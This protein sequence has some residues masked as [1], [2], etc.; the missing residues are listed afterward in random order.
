[1]F[2]R[3]VLTL[4]MLTVFTLGI[5][6]F[7]HGEIYPFAFWGMY[8][9]TVSTMVEFRLIPSDAAREAEENP[10][11][12]ESADV[13]F[14]MPGSVINRSMLQKFGRAVRSGDPEAETYRKSVE[15]A[16]HLEPG[17]YAL[18]QLRYHPIEM[19]QHNQY[20]A[21]LVLESLGRSQADGTAGSP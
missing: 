10:S 13:P 4:L 16:F 9:R 19:H 2:H 15:K 3:T 14:I 8:A 11:Y 20:Q 5:W 21:N 6:G 7:D 12:L 17:T 18:V 1:M